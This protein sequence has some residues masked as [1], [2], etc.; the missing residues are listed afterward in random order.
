MKAA[1][2]PLLITCVQGR[3][4]HVTADNQ[5]GP[6]G[7]DFRQQPHRPADPRDLLGTGGYLEPEYR[8]GDE[9]R[10]DAGN[11]VLQPVHFNDPQPDSELH[12]DDRADGDHC[13]AGDRG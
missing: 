5:T 11:R 6:V 2:V 7:P 12:P 3:L 8:A 4:D 9:Y 10:S 1:S 13:I